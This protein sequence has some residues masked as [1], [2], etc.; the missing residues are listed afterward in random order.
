MSLFTEITV[1]LSVRI[2]LDVLPPHLDVGPFHFTL[3]VLDD[4]SGDI[5]LDLFVVLVEPID[6]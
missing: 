2:V 1:N 4:H 6:E 3:L 5:L